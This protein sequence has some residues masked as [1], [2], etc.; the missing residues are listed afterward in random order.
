MRTLA[1]S[2]V[3]YHGP[4]LVL[5]RIPGQR[6]DQ[7]RGGPPGRLR[8][9][10]SARGR[11]QEAAERHRKVGAAE[12]GDEYRF[13]IGSGDK[14]GRRAGINCRGPRHRDRR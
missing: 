2:I 12:A 9:D 8:L 14:V 4:Q 13:A 1:H 11:R 10:V 5:E 6:G 3:E 7:S